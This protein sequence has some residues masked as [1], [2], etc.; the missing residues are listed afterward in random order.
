MSG[1]GGGSFDS[2]Y[3]QSYGGGPSRNNYSQRVSPYGQRKLAL[4]VC[5]TYCFTAENCLFLGGG[6]RRY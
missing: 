3:Q 5:D 4:F 2:N 1:A 6:N